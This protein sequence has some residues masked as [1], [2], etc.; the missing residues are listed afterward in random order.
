MVVDTSA[1]MALLRGEPEAEWIDN[2]LRASPQT[3]IAAANHVELMIVVESRTGLLA[4]SSPTTSSGGWRLPAKRSI[5]GSPRWPL[6]GGVDSGKAD[7][8]RA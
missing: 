3:V 5:I 8:V 6:L 1:I 2:V 7:I 4:F